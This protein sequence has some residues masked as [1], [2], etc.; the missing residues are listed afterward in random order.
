MSKNQSISH[1]VLELIHAHFLPVLEE[2]INNE[3]LFIQAFQDILHALTLNGNSDFP[4]NVSRHFQ[5]YQQFL[6]Q[7]HALLKGR[8]NDREPHTFEELY[9]DYSNASN[10]LLIG[11]RKNKKEVQ[12]SERFLPQPADSSRIKFLKFWKRQFYKFSQLPVKV[13]NLFRKTFRKPPLPERSWQQ[14]VPYR[15]LA[16]LC[17]RDQLDIDLLLLYTET[18]LTIAKTSALAWE[19]EEMIFS[20][21]YP[22]LQQSILGTGEE[23]LVFAETDFQPKIEVMKGLLE[24]HR[25]NLGK[26]VQQILDITL[27]RFNDAQE[28]A[29]TLELGDRKINSKLKQ[30]QHELDKVYKK[31]TQEWSN[32]L[33]SLHEDWRIDQELNLLSITL[34]QAYLVMQQQLQEKIQEKTLPELAGTRH[35]LEEILQNIDNQADDKP[36]EVRALKKVLKQSKETVDTRLIKHML[37]KVVEVLYKQKISETFDTLSHQI[38]DALQGVSHERGLVEMKTYDRPVKS[39]E[40]NFVSPH[41]I[42]A[43]ESLPAFINGI[44]DY[45]KKVNKEQIQIQQRIYEIGQIA[46]FNLDT[47]LSACEDGLQEEQPPLEIAREGLIRAEKSV[48]VIAEKL[49]EI[50]TEGETR[51]AEDIIAFNNKLNELKNNDYALEIKFRI[52]RAKAIEKARDVREKTVNYAKNF[53]PAALALGVKTYQEG[54]TLLRTYQKRIG[55]ESPNEKVTSEI[56]AFLS[57]TEMAINRL[58]FVYQRLFKIQS[59][60]DDIFYEERT[61]EFNQ[62]NIAFGNWKKG[63][64][65]TTVLVGEKGSGITTLINF[66]VKRLGKNEKRQYKVITA[67]SSEQI[68]G[69]AQFFELFNQIFP[70]NSF[71]QLED[72]TDYLKTLDQ[73]HIIILEHIERL[74]LKKI[75][76][77]ACLKLL[78]ELISKTN[79]QVFWISS[80]TIYGWQYLNKTLNISDYFEY[81]I[82]LENIEDDKMKEVI[83][84]RHRVSGYGLRFQPHAQGNHKKFDKMTEQEQQEKLEEAYFADLNRITDG[85]FSLA[86]LFWMRSALEVTEDT[87][88]MGSLHSLDFSF[89]KSTPLNKTIILHLLLLH[90][91][92]SAAQYTLLTHHTQTE[93]SEHRPAKTRLELLQMLDD[94]LI[95]KENEIYYINP[96]LYR[97]IVGLLRTKNFLY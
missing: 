22:L 80:A 68:W 72:L 15:K 74:Y 35:F 48:D 62:L 63:R 31:N 83:L 56:S 95:V 40:I 47:A 13:Q 58:P 70:G 87:I 3:L 9:E 42:V 45:Q 27:E 26:Y 43:F 20:Q 69:T 82:S 60:E 78:F 90:D 12:K 2:K 25:K 73:P 76:G 37:P 97:P 33:F 65:S 81:V 55:I 61:V 49:A 18:Q 75:G 10:E 23:K 57:E 79:K 32:T 67:S 1:Q 89:I 94:G 85:N 28:K 34:L 21:Y 86:Q 11:L 36:T 41:Q 84:K 17:F 5:S 54:A 96:L 4:N 59:L 7:L 29:G 71:Q 52:A 39:S 93:N 77:F 46:Y 53:L 16:I 19:I 30:K 66:F 92:L 64:Y 6:G 51:L 91:G 8:Y 44:Q 38:H 88:T 50:K 14:I 24:N